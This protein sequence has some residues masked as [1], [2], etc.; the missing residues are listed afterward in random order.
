MNE[1]KRKENLFKRSLEKTKECLVDLT[2][3]VSAAATLIP[4]IVDKLKIVI[5]SL[6]L[7]IF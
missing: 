5:H 1:Y 4:F 6:K 2:I 3:L 7:L